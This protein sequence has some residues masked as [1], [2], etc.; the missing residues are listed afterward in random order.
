[1]YFRYEV[2]GGRLIGTS[3]NESS[4]KIWRKSGFGD[5][6]LKKFYKSDIKT[7]AEVEELVYFCKHLSIRT[8]AS[9]YE[10]INLSRIFV[11]KPKALQIVGAWVVPFGVEGIAEMGYERAIYQLFQWA[12]FN[13][14]PKQKMLHGLGVHRECDLMGVLSED[15]IDEFL[16]IVCESI[17]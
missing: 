8:R 12:V 17:E 5:D 4:D 11:S 7:L 9:L 15:V 6:L 13:F 10:N 2:H 3:L 16:E 1:M 14:K